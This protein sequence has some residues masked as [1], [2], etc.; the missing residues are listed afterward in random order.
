MSRPG[1]PAAAAVFAIGMAG[2]TLPTPLYGLYREELGFSELMVTVVFAVYALGVIATLLLA[3]NVSDETGRRPVLLAAL[4]FSAASA[5]CFLFEGGLPALFAGRLLSG[6][7]AGLLSGAATVTVMELAPPGRAAGAGLAAT[8]ANMGGLGCGPLLAGLLAEYAPW[9]LRLP[10][11]V[12]LALIAAAAVLTWL[13]PETVTSSGR[14]LRLRPQ[15][16]AVPPQV[17]G[18]FA[19]SALAAF[20]GFSLLGL[21]TAVAPAF[22]AETLDVHNLALAG[23]VVFSVFLAST[24]GQALMGRVGERRAL[25]GGCFV[26]VAGLVLVAASLLLASLPLL[27]AGALCGGLGQGLAFRGAV[28]AI[29]AAAPPEHRAATV[30][31]FFVIAYLG[32]SLPV[33][34]V[35]ALTLG[36]G[37]RNA[38]LTFAGCVL[39]LALGVGLYLAR[40]PPARG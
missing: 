31:A 4:G 20:A 8:A 2:T 32:I 40:R 39:V 23:L 1:Y 24:A 3:G 30:S 29:S 26:L 33:V 13:L 10:F 36:I 9:P 34:G 11:V 18:V 25:P 6:F 17:R 21:F 35:G 14:R 15:G 38:G 28:T 7:A 5:L 27:V 22:V 19:P 37:L 16:L 12:H